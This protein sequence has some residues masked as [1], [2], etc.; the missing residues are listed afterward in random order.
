ML[1]TNIKKD[2]LDLFYHVIEDY[3]LDNENKLNLFS[4]E[5]NNTLFNIDSL[6]DELDDNIIPFMLSRKQLRDMDDKFGGKKSR[7]A[8]T[9]FRQFTSNEGELGEVLL[10]CF[11][12]S[13]LN[14]PKILSKYELKTSTNDYIKGA[15]GVHLLK[16]DDST[17]QLI[18]GESK[19]YGELQKGVYDAFSSITT[20][21]NNKNDRYEEELINSN[22]QKEVFDNDSYEVIKNILLPKGRMANNIDLDNSFAI[23]LG[24]NYD[25]NENSKGKEAREKIKK[26]I[27]DIVMANI[28]SINFQLNKENLKGYDFYIYTMPINNIDKTRKDMIKRLSNG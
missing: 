21:L 17:F 7:K 4:L 6:A 14:A 23:F 20:F 9:K 8:R 3:K 28:S 16:T 12:E 18:F 13:H 24:F 26:D 11:L 27:E 19:L 25:L 22:L 1:E 15:D 2:F 5:I 10:Y